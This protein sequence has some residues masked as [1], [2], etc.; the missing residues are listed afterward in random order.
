MIFDKLEN[1]IKVVNFIINLRKH[2]SK[3]YWKVYMEEK[4]HNN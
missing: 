2:R 4:P 1:G 3:K